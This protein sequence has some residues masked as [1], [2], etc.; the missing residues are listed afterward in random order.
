[1]IYIWHSCDEKSLCHFFQLFP[2]YPSPLRSHNAS[3]TCSMISQYS[4]CLTI[5]KF[6]IL[7]TRYFSL[8]LCVSDLLGG[9][10]ITRRG[11]NGGT[12]SLSRDRDS[13]DSGTR[14]SGTVLDCSSQQSS[15]YFSSQQDWFGSHDSQSQHISQDSYRHSQ[16][17]QVRIP[18]SADQL[19]K[20][21]GAPI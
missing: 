3:G 10:S 4:L 15:Q 14:D 18:Y 12:S 17:H 5:Y 21:S 19:L 16:P 2:S 6:Y 7:T 13:S 20:G 11:D 8:F 9:R 1:M